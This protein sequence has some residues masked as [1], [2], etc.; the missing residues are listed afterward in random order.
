MKTT[1]KNFTISS[2]YIGNKP[3]PADEKNYHNHKVTVLSG[4]KKTSFEYW[5]SIMY[6]EISN[7]IDLLNAFECFVMDALSAQNN[8]EDFC[9]ELGYDVSRKAERVYK[10]CEKSLLKLE[11][12]YSGDVCGL[13]NEL[14]ET[15]ND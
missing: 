10:A 15:I 9:N 6:P 4:G 14:R 7:E 11:R 1:Y 2:Q 3:W 5:G 13:A 12:I 8:F